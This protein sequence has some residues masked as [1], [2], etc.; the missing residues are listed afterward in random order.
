[1]KRKIN[2]SIIYI[3]S[4]LA[5]KHKLILFQ[6]SIKRLL[7]TN[8]IYSIIKKKKFFILYALFKYKKNLFWK[9]NHFK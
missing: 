1:M 9:N 5:F 3:I 8:T 4:L 6:E 7:T 2:F